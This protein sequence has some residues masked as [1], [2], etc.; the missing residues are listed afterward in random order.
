MGSFKL[1]PFQL[2]LIFLFVDHTQAL[3]SKSL[4]C[5]LVWATISD[6]IPETAVLGHNPYHFI[7]RGIF[8][9]QMIVGTFSILT[10]TAIFLENSKAISKDNF[11]ILANPH[12]CT[13]QW[14]RS[15]YGD[16]P[17]Y[18]VETF[19]SSNRFIGKAAVAEYDNL[20]WVGEVSSDQQGLVVAIEEEV[21]Q[22]FS[23]YE[24]LTS[25]SEGL[26][27]EM[28]EFVFNTDPFGNKNDFLGIE[29]IVN[30]SPA[31]INQ[32]ITH[33]K[34]IT[35]I[36]TVTTN[37][38]WTSIKTKEVKVKV[39]FVTVTKTTTTKWEEAESETISTTEYREVSVSRLVSVPPYTSIQACSKISI[40]EDV[41]IEYIAKAKY[42][43][44]GLPNETILQILHVEGISAAEIVGDEVIV[45][46][47]RGLFSASLAM[48]T[49]FFVSP[50]D[51]PN[52]CEK[53]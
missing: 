26:I 12:G 47:V 41:D 6:K 36:H 51:S 34:R 24:V 13:V 40:K 39:V 18:A 46:N 28:T 52:G 30:D 16:V 21:V 1:V 4:P 38:T 20:W 9:N 14:T 49:E 3:S 2:L 45:R 19:E 25:F 17:Q 5:S 11:E 8:N 43:A 29:K 22:E 15:S 33:R 35:E 37:R 44:L 31:T 7:A 32:M 27:L 23:S 48:N 53:S 50:L 42:S 10:N